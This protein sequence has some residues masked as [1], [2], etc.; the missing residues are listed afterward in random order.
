[1]GEVK[2][3]SKAA[4]IC[5]PEMVLSQQKPP[6]RN[7]KVDY[8]SD[9]ATFGVEQPDSRRCFI[10]AGNDKRSMVG[11]SRFARRL[12]NVVMLSRPNVEQK[13]TDAQ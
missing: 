13:A 1:M 9:F 7:R 2:E 11:L 4:T 3:P 10:E 8:L 5:R 6:R 12:E